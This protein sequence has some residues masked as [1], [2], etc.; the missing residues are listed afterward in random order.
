HNLLRNGVRRAL[1]ALHGSK[2]RAG[3]RFGMR[4][5]YALMKFLPTWCVNGAATVGGVGYLGPMPGTNGTLAGVLFYWLLLHGQ[6]L[7]L[8]LIAATVLLVLAWLF[9][10]EADR[11]MIGR[12]P[13]KLVLDEFAVLP[14]V[15][16]GFSHLQG[17]RLWILLITGFVLFRV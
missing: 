3:E 17:N 13:G 11:R 7:W 2:C 15:F 1:L 12:D 6:P 9:C 4:D 14:L 5:G 16:L 10:D 8:Q